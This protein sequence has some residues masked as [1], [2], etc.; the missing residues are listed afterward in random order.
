[1]AATLNAIVSLDRYELRDLLAYAYE[2]G[3]SSAEEKYVSV[4]AACRMTGLSRTI[5]QKAIDRGELKC[6]RVGHRIGCNNQIS[7][8]LLKTWVDTREVKINKLSNSN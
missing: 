4:A 6:A 5:V 1:M 3:R 8:V 2:C 7:T